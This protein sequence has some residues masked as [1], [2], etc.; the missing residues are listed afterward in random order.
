MTAFEYLNN[1]Q[2]PK[3]DSTLGDVLHSQRWIDVTAAAMDRALEVRRP[4][5]QRSQHRL[6]GRV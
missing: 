1:A 5:A 4:L 6:P 2:D 3:G